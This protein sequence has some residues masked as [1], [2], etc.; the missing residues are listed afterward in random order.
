[1]SEYKYN[2]TK[3]SVLDRLER[4][5]IEPHSRFYWMTQEYGLWAAWAT[6]VALGSLALAVLAFSSLYIGYSLYEATHNNLLTF[7]FDTL[8]YIWFGAFIVMILAAYFN[9]KRTRKGYKYPFLLLVGSSFGFSVIGGIC[10]HF[11]GAGYYLDYILGENL[12]TYQSRVEF[13]TLMWQA[14][15]AGRLVG[16]ARVPDQTSSI[17]G[18]LFKDVKRQ[19]WQLVVSDLGKKDINLLLSGMKVRI[20]VATSSANQENVRVVC[21]VFPWLLDEAPAIA[22]LRED[23]RTFRQNIQDRKDKVIATLEKVEQEITNE[24]ESKPNPERVR[25]PVGTS[26]TALSLST[27]SGNLSPCA[28]LPLYQPQRVAPEV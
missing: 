28:K 14:P 7:L 20:L 21:G 19:D 4:E 23:R 24:P 27:A 22:K 13:E 26:S 16:V 18:M 2:S 10:L 1:M 6:S 15:S 3:E 9:L 17:P 25:E 12:E 11:L 8:P 5:G